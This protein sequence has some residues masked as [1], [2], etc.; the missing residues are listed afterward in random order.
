MYLTT[1]CIHICIH[2]NE[3]D[4]YLNTFE[5]IHPGLF[6]P[7]HPKNAKVCTFVICALKTRIVEDSCNF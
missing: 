1:I 4:L 7:T 2:G 3:K 6:L 5:S